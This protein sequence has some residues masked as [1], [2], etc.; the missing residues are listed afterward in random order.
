MSDV[1]PLVDSLAAALRRPVA[2]DDRRLRA[3]A[4]SAHTGKIDAV[5]MASLLRRGASAPVAEWLE[6]HRIAT[7]RAP[8]RI[9]ANAALGASARI[10]V[11]MRFDDVLLGFLWLIDEPVVDDAELRTAERAAEE[12]ARCV[13]R[14]ERLHEDD[15]EH[16]G[17]LA[18]QL[19]QIRPGDP[20]A[21]AGALIDGGWLA[22]ARGYATI[23]LQPY[24]TAPG[25]LPEVVRLRA[26]DAA[27]QARRG[28]AQRHCI[29][30]ATGDL[31]VWLLAVATA[32]DAR[33]RAE[34]L[35]HAARRALAASDCRPV[36]GV[37]STQQTVAGLA[38]SHRQA[39]DALRIGLAC[40][41]T[42]TVI[43]WSELGAYRTLI[44]LLG[45]R[46]ASALVPDSVLE[47]LD[48][49]ST[50][51]LTHTLERYLELGC[52][53]GAAA[54]ELTLHRSSLYARLQRIEEI[55]GMDI[56]SGD[57]RLELQLGLRLWRLGGSRIAAARAHAGD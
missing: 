47:L 27:E 35:A 22:R 12:I 54:Q 49:D 26:V 31:V 36:I 43:C 5:R 19:L 46:D 18:L 14:R 11:P 21:A 53:A 3:I 44:A 33:P 4:Y 6:S 55:I 40:G 8:V 9:P 15:R 52:D 1:Q 16:V 10:C 48:A 25:P 17:D 57:H 7:A 50:G 32:G 37:G 42:N 45:D 51:Q 39:L 23:V 28:I 20:A 41:G 24:T 34:A 2:V 29:A 38:R 56:R 13:Y 30:V